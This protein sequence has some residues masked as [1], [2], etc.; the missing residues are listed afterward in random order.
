MLRHSGNTL[1]VLFMVLMALGLTTSPALAT[2][3]TQTGTCNIST[4]SDVCQSGST[5]LLAS[6]SATITSTSTTSAQPFTLSFTLSNTNNH[7]SAT[8]VAYTLQLFDSAFTIT[9]TNNSL[10][11]NWDALAG[12]KQN[13]SGDPSTCHTATGLSGWLCVTSTTASG[14]GGPLTIAKNSSYTFTFSGSLDAGNTFTSP[15]DLMING[16]APNGTKYAISSSVTQPG[17]PPPHELPEPASLLMMGTGLLT[18][19]A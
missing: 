15:F 7:N 11:T 18:V 5:D 13:N 9:P 17:G 19:G 4:T 6:I 2:S 1:V 10:P 8:L 3:V 14:T 16:I 12:Y